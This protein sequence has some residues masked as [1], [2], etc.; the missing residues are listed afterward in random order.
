MA[1]LKTRNEIH[2]GNVWEFRKQIEKKNH[3]SN[4]TYSVAMKKK[5]GELEKDTQKLLSMFAEY[6]EDPL[7]TR[8]AETMKEI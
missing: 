6:C 7:T 1:N 8:K 5:N 3:K 4:T 2:N